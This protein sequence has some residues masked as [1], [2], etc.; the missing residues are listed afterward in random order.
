MTRFW[1]ADTHFSHSNI[2]RY[3]TR[4]QLKT[5]YLNDDGSW[6]SPEAAFKC[7]EHM[8]KA[9]IRD[10]NMRVKPEDTVICVG[11]FACRGGEKG[12]K[13]AHQKPSEILAQLTGHWV[14]V[15]G[16]HDQNNGVKASCSF[17]SC[18]ISKYRVGVQHI[19]LQDEEA[20]CKW[21]AKPRDYRL[22]N[23][24]RD[25]MSP[26]VRKREYFH[27]EYC[28][29]MFDFM[30]VGHVHNTWNVKK[31]AG[32]WHINVGV[33]LNRYMPI[34]DNEVVLLYEKAKRGQLW[35]SRKS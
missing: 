26:D 29:K 27:A 35:K 7:T 32:L 5:C 34:N 15:E 18:K 11:D 17:M 8:N 14:F 21:M 13:G 22:K 23:P 31:V 2:V 4:P 1:I 6:I 33:D 19:P 10:A 16:N 20:R 3:C 9:L 12:V 28:R 24:W 30:I 25:N